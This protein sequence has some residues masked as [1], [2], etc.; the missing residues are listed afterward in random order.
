MK[1]QDVLRPFLKVPTLDM[2]VTLHVSWYTWDL[3]KPLLPRVLFPSL[4]LP[5]LSGLSTVGSI[6]YLLY[7]EAVSGTFTFKCF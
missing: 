7:Q 4:F 3:S 2:L 5:R 1:A 6:C